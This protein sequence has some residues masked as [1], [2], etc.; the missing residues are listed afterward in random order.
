VDNDGEFL[1]FLHKYFGSARFA[2][3]LGRSLSSHNRKR[4]ATTCA[5]LIDGACTVGPAVN[6]VAHRIMGNDDD[7]TLHVGLRRLFVIL[8]RYKTFHSIHLLTS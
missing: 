8:F 7:M 3:G 4:C 2:L 1:L 5:T 6:A